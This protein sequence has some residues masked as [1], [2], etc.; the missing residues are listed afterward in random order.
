MEI[1]RTS[2]PKDRQLSVDTAEGENELEHS[3]EKPTQIATVGTGEPQDGG[4]PVKKTR[5]AGKKKRK[6]TSKT[7]KSV[8]KKSKP[9][10]ATANEGVVDEVEILATSTV[11]IGTSAP[12]KK[13]LEADDGER[14]IPETLV[15]TATQA[16][17]AETS[18]QSRGSDDEGS[19]GTIDRDMEEHSKKV[20]L[21]YEQDLDQIFDDD[22]K[23]LAYR[24]QRVRQGLT[25]SKRTTSE[26]SLD[27]VAGVEVGS[28]SAAGSVR[29]TASL[30]ELY[31]DITQSLHDPTS[32]NAAGSL[33][34]KKIVERGL[35][36]YDALDPQEKRKLFAS[37]RLL[38]ERAR[39]AQSKTLLALRSKE[40]NEGHEGLPG[41]DLPE[42]VDGEVLDVHAAGEAAKVNIGMFDT[43]QPQ[44]P[45][46]EEL[47]R[48]VTINYV[49]SQAVSSYLPWLSDQLGNV[50]KELH[51]EIEQRRF[52]N[53][54]IHGMLGDNRNYVETLRAEV[55][56]LRDLVN[57]MSQ[58]RST[59]AAHGVGARHLMP[60]IDILES[61]DMQKL[62][63]WLNLVGEQMILEPSFQSRRFIHEKLLERFCRNESERETVFYSLKDYYEKGKAENRQDPMR[64]LK[65]VKYP[66][67]GDSRERFQTY[68]MN[69]NSKIDPGFTDRIGEEALIELLFEIPRKVPASFGLSKEAIR[70]K[71]RK[72]ENPL[73]SIDALQNLLEAQRQFALDRGVGASTGQVSETGTRLKEKRM[74]T[75]TVSKVRSSLVNQVAG[76]TP[77]P[78][79]S[80][81]MPVNITGPSV[82]VINKEKAFHDVWY[83]EISWST[84]RSCA[85]CK[86]HGHGMHDCV[87]FA[88]VVIKKDDEKRLKAVEG[89]VLRTRQ[90]QEFIN[91]MFNRQAGD[92]EGR[93]D[94]KMDRGNTS[95][96]HSAIVKAR[97]MNAG[98][99]SPD[100]ADPR[101]GFRGSKV[102][103]LAA[104]SGKK[105]LETVKAMVPEDYDPM[106][107][108]TEEYVT[109]DVHVGKLDQFRN[110]DEG[111]EI[112]TT[113]GDVVGDAK[114]D[115]GAEVTVGSWWKHKD[116]LDSYSS[117]KGRV[118]V[119]N[120]APVNVLAVGHMGLLVK[121]NGI[122]SRSCPRAKVVLVQSQDWPSFLIGR[123]ELRKMGLDPIQNLGLG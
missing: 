34:E 105:E 97:M 49:N 4:E 29:N 13:T 88:A 47:K 8:A 25:I 6:A 104:P 80:G 115:S 24:K 11:D 72:T 87:M 17:R 67:L 117:A 106:I 40:V 38:Y 122:E 75:P 30:N 116:L 50:Q 71:V 59:H 31:K 12:R 68:M 27:Y 15:A 22:R 89:D 114:F 48:F 7:V 55:S 99:V 84:R 74:K 102:L 81:P 26:G 36:E 5:K 20:T 100:G 73:K 10:K 1:L 35:R 92:P 3:V 95:L 33:V 78:Q 51:Q 123:P 57:M 28:H 118:H 79:A 58:T 19:H 69:V 16:S 2:N 94:Y 60:K 41:L 52:R 98:K 44:D 62:G 70:A 54:E 91:R 111:Y 42:R 37:M 77:Y 14:G 107:E 18:S 61:L 85:Y 112:C 65:E 43:I 63:Q 121:V 86:N 46:T 120:D 39:V 45:N 113:K 96:K 119:A 103:A 110:F 93:T 82:K 64:L 21:G 66:G 32:G 53:R 109:I 108:G 9:V 56:S 90:V 83:S 76:F 101:S 23:I